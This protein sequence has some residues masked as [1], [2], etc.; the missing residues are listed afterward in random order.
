MKKQNEPE[1]DDYDKGIH[2][3]C[4]LI[5]ILII[6]A[7]FAM[8]FTSCS[9]TKRIT[10]YEHEIVTNDSS[11]VVNVKDTSS[12]TIS[13]SVATT[14]IYSI[15]SIITDDSS[16]IHLIVIDYDTLGHKVRESIIDINKG[17]HSVSGNSTSSYSKNEEIDISETHSKDSLSESKY[18]STYEKEHKSKVV[19]KKSPLFVLRFAFVL[20]VI[21]GLCFLIFRVIVKLK[22]W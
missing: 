13:S 8:T 19:E 18:S 1:F 11:V 4:I 14:D 2:I 10:E 15:S 3:F 12:F 5:I 9:S 16:K 6:I 17:S 21:L 22:R 20:F 7:G